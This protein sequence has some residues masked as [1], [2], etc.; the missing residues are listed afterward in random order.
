VK[1]KISAVSLATIV[2]V[3]S[4]IVK[5][6]ADTELVLEEDEPSLLPIAFG[7]ISILSGNQAPN[8]ICVS[9]NGTIFTVNAPPL[10]E[11][12]RGPAPVSLVA[13]RDNCSVLWLRSFTSSD[14]VPYGIETDQS[15]IFITGCRGSILFL[16]KYNFQGNN[17]WNITRNMGNMSYGIEYGQRIFILADESIVVSGVSQNYSSFEHSSCFIAS[18]SQDGT[19]NWGKEFSTYPCPCID[20]SFIYILNQNTIQKL[21]SRG[22]IL[23]SRED[24]NHI[25]LGVSSEI[26]FTIKY[27]W[28]ES[29]FIT[30]RSTETGNT[31]WSSN[32]EMCDI[33]HQSYNVSGI[34]SELSQDD[35]LMI[36]T[37]VQN[38]SSFYLLDINQNGELTSKTK[39]LNHEWDYPQFDLSSTG[40]RIFVAGRTSEHG[41]SVAVFDSHQLTPFSDSHP[42]NIDLMLVGEV[43]TGVF[44]FDVGLIIYLRR[45]GAE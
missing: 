37:Q 43:A 17:V 3:C 10:W 6:G 36:L 40:D 32:C 35:S 45:R 21:D 33:N 14:F 22:R 41:L 44:L 28:Y 12:Y 25:P 38:F 4:L 23:W 9:N 30:A 26:L 2:I 31:R 20:S 1:L 19:F 16:G 42:N 27:P 24:Y 11:L 5:V 34:D 18:F 39:I 29:L 8:D 7:N 13:W 15:H